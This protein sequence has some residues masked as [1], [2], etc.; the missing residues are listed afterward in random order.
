MANRNRKLF[1]TVAILAGACALVA[2]GLIIGG[3][4]PKGVASYFYSGPAGKII[5]PN[6]AIVAQARAQ[7]GNVPGA[8][9][10]SIAKQAQAADQPKPD[11]TLAGAGSGTPPT[12]TPAQPN[13][14]AG[15]TGTGDQPKS[16][17]GGDTASQGDQGKSSD[18]SGS[19]GSSGAKQGE[20]PK[21]DNPPAES[22]DDSDQ[23]KD[24][25]DEK[26]PPPTYDRYTSPNGDDVFAVTGVRDN[27]Y[28]LDDKTTFAGA[29]DP[30]DTVRTFII[31]LSGFQG[32]PPKKLQ[33]TFLTPS[34][35]GQNPDVAS[36]NATVQ[37]IRPYEEY[38]QNGLLTLVGYMPGRTVFYQSVGPGTAIERRTIT[39]DVP[40][41]KYVGLK[42]SISN[43][44]PYEAV[45]YSVLVRDANLAE[46]ADQ[47]AAQSEAG[48][49][50]GG[51]Q[52]Q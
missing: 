25:S 16:D 5:R 50:Q 27:G 35:G 10:Q 36:V 19:G 26:A 42:V 22:T 46:Q 13:E 7:Q 37:L 18:Q 14:Q 4:L 15:Q 1:M 20:E 43:L 21:S 30:S 40:S 38:G 3:A 34:R 29:G 47:A 52:Q 33:I 44:N 24:K 31:D 9:P 11:G 8:P 48:A 12:S 17:N 32:D 51:S 49:V 41:Q 6:A 45:P 28:I 2:V 23:S 39:V